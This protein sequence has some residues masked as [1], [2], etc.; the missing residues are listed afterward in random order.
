MCSTVIHLTRCVRTEDCY[1][2][3]DQSTVSGFH[4]THSSDP[5]S[6]QLVWINQSTPT[7]RL[8]VLPECHSIDGIKYWF[9]MSHLL[10]S[11]LYPGLLLTLSSHNISVRT[12][13]KHT[14]FLWLGWTKTLHFSHSSLFPFNY[15]IT[16][17]PTGTNRLKIWWQLSRWQ[18][19]NSTWLSY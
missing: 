14:M 15:I 12:W 9:N 11:R 8:F 17:Y 1:L 18:V 3:S 7:E 5:L 4:Q 19:R 13:T 2:Y 10:V 16:Y 6:N